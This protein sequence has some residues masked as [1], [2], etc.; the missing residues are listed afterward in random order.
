VFWVGSCQRISGS[1]GGASGHKGSGFLFDT[2]GQGTC[3]V[4]VIVGVMVFIV[5]VGV[6]A[7]KWALFV[8]LTFVIVAFV[9]GLCVSVIGVA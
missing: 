7:V 5:A 2:H 4:T 9:V 1:N 8:I 3:F 6:V